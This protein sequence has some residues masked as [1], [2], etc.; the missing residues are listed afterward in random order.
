MKKAIKTL[1]L[2]YYGFYALAVVLAACGYFFLAGQPFLTDKQG[3]LSVT[4][5]SVYIILLITSIPLALKLFNVKTQR[6]ADDEGT[7][8]EKAP[9]YLRLAACR[10]TVIGTNLLAGIALFYLLGSQS[11][12]FCAGIAAVALVFCKPR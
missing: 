1:T 3:T 9:R 7:E 11:M 5:S 4:L 12:L 6:L 8:D 2:M 10:L